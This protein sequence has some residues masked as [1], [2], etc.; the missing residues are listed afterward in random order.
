MGEMNPETEEAVSLLGREDAVLELSQESDGG[1]IEIPLIEQ[2]E[3]P[4]RGKERQIWQRYNRHPFSPYANASGGERSVAIVEMKG[5]P[6]CRM[7]RNGINK[8]AFIP[9]YFWGS[10]GCDDEFTVMGNAPLRLSSQDYEKWSEREYQERD[11]I[12]VIG[13][14]SRSSIIINVGRGDGITAASFL[15]MGSKKEALGYLEEEGYD[16]GSAGSEYKDKK[17]NKTGVRRKGKTEAEKVQLEVESGDVSIQL[18]T[19][20]ERLRIAGRLLRIGGWDEA[21]EWFRQAYGSDFDERITH[22]QLKGIVNKYE[23]FSHIEVP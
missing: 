15:K 13:G 7:S 8:G 5:K 9:A 18:L 11:V 2:E 6:F 14:M 12:A 4:G 17:R 19:H 3:R 10:I 1:D 22:T 21:F 23:D 20:K 16:I